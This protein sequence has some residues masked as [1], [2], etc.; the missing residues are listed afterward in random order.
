MDIYIDSSDVRSVTTFLKDF[1]I[2]PVHSHKGQNGKVLV[3]GGSHLFHAAY[4]WA[5]EA[6]S[7][8]IDML[9]FAS[10]KE[11]NSILIQLKSQ[12]RNGIVIEQKD[13]PW[14]ADEDD[15]ILI[16]PGMVRAESVSVPD[17]KVDSYEKILAL[18][19]ESDFTYYITKHLMEQ[20]P[21]KRFVLDAGA[22][23]MM[24]ADWLK[25]M[26]QMPVICPHQLE[27]ERLFGRPVRSLDMKAKIRLVKELAAEYKTVIVLKAV[28]DIISDGKAV[29]VVEGGNPGLTKGGSGD[30]LG[31]VI[32]AF[33]AKNEPLTSAVIAS[34][35][36]K[37]TAD[38][39][40]QDKGYWYNISNLID[41]MPA[42]LKQLVND[43]I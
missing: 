5:A 12:F 29:V 43:R 1:Y 35:I 24:H 33:Y 42:T 25:H 7:Y 2:P 30:V 39:L 40:S 34:F 14:Y 19:Q 13:I 23:Q 9:H 6:A 37:R 8:Y 4:L 27:F 38:I 20:F 26:K 36:M 15:A 17:E 28:A 3:I 21:H 11:N 10:T 41:K 18:E 22:L 16:G 31:G 32:A